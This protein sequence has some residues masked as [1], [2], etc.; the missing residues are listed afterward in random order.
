MLFLTF[1]WFLYPKSISKAS[2]QRGAMF[3]YFCCSC[4]AGE[5]P[6]WPGSP[7]EAL[8]HFHWW[9][10]L[11]VW[12]QE[13]E[14]ER[15]R[16]PHQDRVPGPDAGWA[17]RKAQ[18][19]TATLSGE[20]ATSDNVHC[21]SFI[22]VGNNNDGILVL[23]AT[24][25][26]WVL[27]SAIRRRS[28]VTSLHSFLFCLTKCLFR[29]QSCIL[30]S[31]RGLNT[32]STSSRGFTEKDPVSLRQLPWG[33]RKITMELEADAF[34]GVYP[35]PRP[36]IYCNKKIP[37]GGAGGALKTKAWIHLCLLFGLYE[38]TAQHTVST[39]WTVCIMVALWGSQTGAASH[40]SVL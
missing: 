7:A 38:H 1:Y 28:E 14:R 34:Q 20:R 39:C 9:G 2:H 32:L 3:M 27:D 25:I 10:G 6:V 24:N 33:L 16:A 22:G 37:P 30:E 40:H 36:A 13:R 5:E 17:D 23:G 4:K 21:S 11:P 26:P 15:S 12:L 8:H 29:V 18:R 31:S 35:S 19:G